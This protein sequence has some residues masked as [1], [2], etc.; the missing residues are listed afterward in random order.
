MDPQTRKCMMIINAA[1]GLGATK[2]AL[3]MERREE[4][5]QQL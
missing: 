4:V 1:V 3:E 2:L 5:E